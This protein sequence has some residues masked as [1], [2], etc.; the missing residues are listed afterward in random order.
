M[1]RQ[2]A[3]PWVRGDDA[4]IFNTFEQ[5]SVS[6]QI[7]FW[8]IPSS[9]LPLPFRA[10]FVAAQLLPQRFSCLTHGH[11]MTEA[12]AVLS[13]AAVISHH[14]FSMFKAAVM[15][16][17]FPFCIKGYNIM[18]LEQKKITKNKRLTRPGWGPLKMEA[19]LSRSMIDNY[20][21]Y[22]WPTMTCRMGQ[23]GHIAR[24][25]HTNLFPSPV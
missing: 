7:R 3:H 11:S 15:S 13:P 5:D 17:S 8:L 16:S 22:V 23:I 1:R 12:A 14:T 6:C 20:A 9:S 25:G 19:L 10:I 18:P 24:T 21:N 2:E 4:A